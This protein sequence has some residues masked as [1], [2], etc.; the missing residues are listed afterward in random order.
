MSRRAGLSRE[1]VVWAAAELADQQG[2]DQLT[3]AQVAEQLGV[4]L[5]SLYNHVAGLPG[6]HRELAVLGLCQLLEHIRQAALGRAGDAAVIAVAQAIRHF[7]NE[8]PGLY[9]ATIPAIDP[10]DRKLQQSSDAI[11]GV[12]LIVLGH[13][14]LTEQDAIHAIRGLRSIT[15]GFA[16]LE[17][18]GGF[19]LPL[20]RDESFLRLLRT[21]IAGLQ[22]LPPQEQRP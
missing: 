21:Y 3:L 2:L 1:R 13:Y 16:T 14:G 4:R 7:V 15:H 8:R 10:N 20:D 22:Q 6:L 19:G 17:A 12:L 18:A 9:A 11:I 5:P